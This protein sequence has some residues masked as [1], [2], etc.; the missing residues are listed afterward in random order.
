MESSNKKEMDKST[1]AQLP[2]VRDQQYSQHD[3]PKVG[4]GFRFITIRLKT[5]SLHWVI[6]RQAVTSA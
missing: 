2:S 6:T 4:F 3:Q 1:I 5:G